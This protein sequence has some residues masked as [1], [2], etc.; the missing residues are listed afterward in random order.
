MS[1]YTGVTLDQN[2]QDQDP[3]E[4]DVGKDGKLGGIRWCWTILQKQTKKKE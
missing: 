1:K 3:E 4:T 2:V